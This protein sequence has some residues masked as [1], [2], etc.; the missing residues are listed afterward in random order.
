M[1]IVDVNGARRIAQV[2]GTA[3]SVG[4]GRRSDGLGYSVQVSDWPAVSRAE[5]EFFLIAGAWL[6]RFCHLRTIASII[7]GGRFR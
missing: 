1:A 6:M 3:E 7:S 2:D 5:D 4:V